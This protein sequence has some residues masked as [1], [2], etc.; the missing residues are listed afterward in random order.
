MSQVSRRKLHKSV[1]EKIYNTLWEAVAKLN[2]DEEIKLFLND[3]LSPTERTMIAKRLAIASLLAKGHTY[4]VIKDLLKV[5]QETV[6]KVSIAM[7]QSSGYIST[8]N[9]IAKSEATREFW[10]DIES[11]LYRISSPGKVFMPEN[12]IKYKLGHKKKTLV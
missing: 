8:I 6:A 7:S 5:S 3:L 1:E 4:D 12:A 11:A 10:K 9:K 2:S